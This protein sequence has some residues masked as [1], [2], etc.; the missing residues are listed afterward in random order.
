MSPGRMQTAAAFSPADGDFAGKFVCKQA[1]LLAMGLRVRSEDTPILSFVGRLVHHKGFDVLAEAVTRLFNEDDDI[2]LIGC[3]GGY[4]EIAARLTPSSRVSR[5][6]SA[7]TS[8]T[9]SRSATRSSRA[10]TSASCHRSMRPAAP[11]T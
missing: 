9:T 2:V 10:A 5:T 7:F 11:W 8:A 1:L 4:P 3:G 6:G